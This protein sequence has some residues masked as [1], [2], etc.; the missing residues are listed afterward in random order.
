MFHVN[1]RMF[2]AGCTFPRQEISVAKD[3]KVHLSNMRKKRRTGF[4]AD[5]PVDLSKLG[6]NYLAM[7]QC[8]KYL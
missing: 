7:V 1:S 4:E 3:G 6:W 2:P 8:M 5:S